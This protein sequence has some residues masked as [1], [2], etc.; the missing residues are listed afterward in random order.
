ML[1]GARASL[2]RK[3]SPGRWYENSRVH[4]SAVGHSAKMADFYMH[5]GRRIYA[6]K[7]DISQSLQKM[8]RLCDLNKYCIESICLVYIL[9]KFSRVTSV[10]QVVMTMNAF[11]D[12]HTIHILNILIVD[13]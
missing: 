9:A 1:L 10:S 13:N 7:A 5:T 2:W 11:P 8:S 6:L 3:T 4:C 12:V